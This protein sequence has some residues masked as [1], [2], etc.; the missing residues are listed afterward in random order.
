[1]SAGWYSDRK[2][3]HVTQKTHK[4]ATRDGGSLGVHYD[5]DATYADSVGALLVVLDPDDQI[6][7][8]YVA[9]RRDEVLDDDLQLQNH[10]DGVALQEAHAKIRRLR[11]DRAERS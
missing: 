3:G 2:A 1:M 10:L 5:G 4:F 7:V 11:A 6:V 8:S 9:E